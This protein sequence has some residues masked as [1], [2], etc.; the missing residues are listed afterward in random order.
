MLS[1]PG[2]NLDIA[3]EKAHLLKQ[4]LHYSNG[5]IES[6]I[7]DAPVSFTYAGFFSIRL[8]KTYIP[9]TDQ[10]THSITNNL[11]GSQGSS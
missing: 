6:C 11:Q 4:S 2:I 7:N 8:Q 1:V 5:N 10:T 3:Q 9:R